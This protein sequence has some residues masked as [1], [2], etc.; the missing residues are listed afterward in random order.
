MNIIKL[1]V[2]MLLTLC[3]SSAIAENEKATIGDV[4]MAVSSNSPG[5]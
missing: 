2:A 5:F 3:I 4:A 1:T